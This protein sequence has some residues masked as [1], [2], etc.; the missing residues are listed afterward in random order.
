MLCSI[1]WCAARF[2]RG[3]STT[4]RTGCSADIRSNCGRP[5]DH[6]LSSSRRVISRGFSAE[7]RYDEQM[8]RWPLAGCLASGHEKDATMRPGSCIADELF[9]GPSISRMDTLPIKYM[10]ACASPSSHT[11]S[12]AFPV[13]LPAHMTGPVLVFPGSIL[14]RVTAQGP[15]N[16]APA[17]GP[18]SRRYVCHSFTGPRPG[19]NTSGGTVRHWRWGRSNT[20]GGTDRT[21]AVAFKHNRSKHLRRPSMH[22]VHNFA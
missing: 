14:S 22:M 12:F 13:C 2:D 1:L 5:R 21:Q 11:A 4:S 16:K 6:R 15:E 18:P 19:T 9:L 10:P 7:R 20:R 8:G 17:T 3:C